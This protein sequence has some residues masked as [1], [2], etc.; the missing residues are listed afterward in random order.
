LRAITVAKLDAFALSGVSY[1][2]Q[3]RV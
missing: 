3:E 1:L 2:I